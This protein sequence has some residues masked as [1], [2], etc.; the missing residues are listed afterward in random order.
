M[1]HSGP[2]LPP[3]IFTNADLYC[4]RWRQVQ[5][6]ADSFWTRWLKEYLPTL[7]LRQKWLHP[8]RNL[9]VGDLV[10]LL[11]ET[12]PCN[13]WP[14]GVVQQVYLGDDGLLRVVQV[15]TQAGTYKR[16]IHKLVLLEAV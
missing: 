14:L 11:H 7:K 15:K 4:R 2:A 10:L 1:L 3:G 8:Q 16:P 12:T 13:N 9:Q 6:L 5:Y